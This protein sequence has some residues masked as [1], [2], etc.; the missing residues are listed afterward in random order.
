MRAQIWD[1]ERQGDLTEIESQLVEGVFKKE[2]LPVKPKKKKSKRR[3]MTQ[4]YD[5]LEVANMGS[6]ELMKPGRGRKSVRVKRA[7][8]G[9]EEDNETEEDDLYERGIH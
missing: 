6:R 7:S 5:D 3:R 2:K 4:T 9:Q 1:K 8:K